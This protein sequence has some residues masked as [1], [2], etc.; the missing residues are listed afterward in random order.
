MRRN[1]LRTTQFS[2]W[3]KSHVLSTELA[4]RQGENGER[5]ASFSIV[6]YHTCARLSRGFQKKLKYFFRLFF[7]APQPC[8][9]NF[10]YEYIF[11]KVRGQRHDLRHFSKSIVFFAK[12]YGKF[13]IFFYSVSFCTKNSTKNRLFWILPFL[14]IQGIIIT[15]SAAPTPQHHAQRSHRPCG[16]SSLWYQRASMSYGCAFFNPRDR[17]SVSLFSF[18]LLLY[19]K[20]WIKFKKIKKPMEKSFRLCYNI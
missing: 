3:E 9:F 12:F 7:C 14:E 11:S 15:L 6:L 4:V 13:R 1:L 17:N 20:L 2:L 16:V 19:N 5:S 8:I 10:F 18:C